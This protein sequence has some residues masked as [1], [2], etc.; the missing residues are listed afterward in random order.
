MI[1]PPGRKHFLKK[2]A[3]YPRTH[4][5]ACTEKPSL[6]EDSSSQV[7]HSRLYTSLGAPEQTKH[8]GVAQR[9]ILPGQGRSFFYFFL[10]FTGFQSATALRDGR[11]GFHSGPFLALRPR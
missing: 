4:N 6:F 1:I 5:A 3:V 9:N 11:Q 7:T 8:Q 10:A 2:A